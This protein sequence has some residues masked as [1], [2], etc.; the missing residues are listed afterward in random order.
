MDEGY[1]ISKETAKQTLKRFDIEALVNGVLSRTATDTIIISF[2]LAIK[3]AIPALQISASRR[4][5]RS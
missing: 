1:G 2:G 5:T 3:K 4:L